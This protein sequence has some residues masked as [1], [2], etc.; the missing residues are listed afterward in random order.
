MFNYQIPCP[1]L[2]TY[3]KHY[4]KMKTN[5]RLWM[6]SLQNKAQPLCS[7]FPST[8][9][10]FQWARRRRKKRKRKKLKRQPPPRK[11][12]RKVIRG[13]HRTWFNLFVNN[14]T[15]RF[16]WFLWRK[17]QINYK[18]TDGHIQEIRST[19]SMLLLLQFTKQIKYFWMSTIIL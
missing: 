6:P 8:L 10:V 9:F 17:L 4:S 11:K 14:S 12:T 7:H 3:I 2:V 19:A 16:G 15:S 13:E 5:F 1:S 18:Q